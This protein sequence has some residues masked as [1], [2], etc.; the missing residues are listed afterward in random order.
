[1]NENKTKVGT[2][3]EVVARFLDEA[4]AKRAKENI[5]ELTAYICEPIREVMA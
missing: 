5:E 1:M 2:L 4:Q 3:F